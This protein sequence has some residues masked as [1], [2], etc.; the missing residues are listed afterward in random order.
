MCVQ[1]SVVFQ[2]NPTGH[3]AIECNLGSR[4]TSDVTIQCV[5]TLDGHGEINHKNNSATSLPC[6]CK[7]L[8]CGQC[9][10]SIVMIMLLYGNVAAAEAPCSSL[11]VLHG[12]QLRLFLGI[13]LCACLTQRYPLVHPPEGTQSRSKTLR[14]YG[15]VSAGKL[16]T[17]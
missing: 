9:L 5:D 16:T 12:N 6:G 10:Q 2:Q 7:R 17:E 15:H 1:G 14:W 13:A 11:S 8:K 4:F 3:S